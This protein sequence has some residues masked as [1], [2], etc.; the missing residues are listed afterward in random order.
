ML[1]VCFSCYCY[2]KSWAFAQLFD[3]YKFLALSIV[4]SMLEMTLAVRPVFSRSSNPA[5]VVPPGLEIL[6]IESCVLSAPC[7]KFS[8]LARTVCVT[9]SNDFPFGIPYLTPALASASI[10][11]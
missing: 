4:A 6:S 7:S 11:S 2:K 10:N 8:A 9:I 3:Y 1:W 5:I